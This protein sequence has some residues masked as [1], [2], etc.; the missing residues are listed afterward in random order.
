MLTRLADADQESC[1]GKATML[2]VLLRAGLPVPDGFVI[3]KADPA[4]GNMKITRSLRAA[5]TA[6]LVRLGDPV[7]AVRSS[8]TGEDGA[9]ASAAGQYESVIGAQGTESVC[10]AIETCRSSAHAPRVDHYWSR[11]LPAAA[12]PAPGMAVLV[13]RMIAP[14]ASGVM[15]T[16]QQAGDPTRIEASWGLGLSVVGGTVTPDTYEVQPDGSIAYAV[17]SK[18]TRIDLDAERGSVTTRTVAADQQRARALDDR[19][20]KILT[21]LGSRIAEILGGPQDVE[22]AVA[23]DAVWVLQARP[24][25]ASLPATRTS[26]LPLSPQALQGTPGAHGVVTGGAR[27]V[28]GPSDFQA[29]QP[30]DIVICHYTDPA[31]TPLFRIA[32][33]VVTETGGA[34]SHAAIVAREYGIPAVLGVPDALNLIE[35]GSQVT[36]DGTA[37]TITPL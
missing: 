35:N 33:G 34:L 24:I 27:I 31:W 37:G 17:G 19:V 7:V 22:W 2:G 25:T 5:V 20:V 23:D 1:G 6:E 26:T 30:G 28:R 9:E 12:P 29:V 10:D 15:F 21:G 32:A 36:L 13:Q 8:A 11:A 14:D 3:P 4:A 16:P 18:Q